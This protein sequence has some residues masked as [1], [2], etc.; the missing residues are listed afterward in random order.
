M[1]VVDGPAVMP[2]PRYPHA[3]V[4]TSCSTSR[5]PLRMTCLKSMN[6]PGRRERGRL[7]GIRRAVSELTTSPPPLQAE[8]LHA[9]VLD[10]STQLRDLRT[11]LRTAVNRF[12]DTGHAALSEIAANM[13]LVATELASNAIKH[14]LPPTT[15]RLSHTRDKIRS[16]RRRP[17]PGHHPRTRRNPPPPRRRT[18]P[19]P[20]PRV[21][22]AG[23]LVRQRHHQ[24]RLGSLPHPPMTC[25]NRPVMA[26]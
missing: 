13:V 5:D 12:A 7:Q 3:Y 22:T 16:R 8:L 6:Q 21:I 14:G 10:D 18:R 20:R 2:R 1:T 24:T 19:A 17:R 11:Y 9:W 26:M 4:I 15:V 25:W 23:R